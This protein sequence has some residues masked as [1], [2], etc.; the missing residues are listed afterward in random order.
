M[1]D[2]AAQAGL[3][4][5]NERLTRQL[6]GRLDQLQ[7]AQKRL[8]AAQDGERRRLE[9]NIHDGAQQQLV[10][11]AVKARLARSLTERDPAKA[12]AMLEQIEIGDAGGA[13]GPARPRARHLSAAARRQGPGG[14]ARRAGSQVAGAG[15]RCDA[16]GIERLPQ[17]VEAAVYFSALEALQ[18]IGEVRGRVVGDGLPRAIERRAAVLGRRRRPRLRSGGERLRHR[19]AGHRRPA[20]RPR[21]RGDGRVGARARHGGVGPAARRTPGERDHRMSTAAEPRA[22]SA[23]WPWVVFAV[24]RR[25][26]DR[27][28]DPRRRQ[29]R[30]A[31]RTVAVRRGLLDVRRRRRPHPQP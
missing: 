14:R 23:R 19:A 5:R 8:V 20:R 16:D 18:N 1:R 29:R 10:A 11:L 4:L 25:H 21:R 17:E 9:R 13:R 7:A 3:V 26:R 15:R 22:A 28:H 12:A 27:R 30:G 24:V 2:L 31:R 6:R